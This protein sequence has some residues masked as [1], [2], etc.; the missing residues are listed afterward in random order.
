[1]LDVRVAAGAAVAE[2]DVLGVVEAMKMELA[3]KAP[4]TG[5][6]TDVAA[7]VGDQVSLGHRLFVVEE[8]S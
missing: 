6:V 1:V 7:A 5:T 8:E 4:F 2:G 3:L